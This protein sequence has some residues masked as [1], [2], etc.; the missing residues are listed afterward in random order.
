MVPDIFAIGFV[1]ATMYSSAFHTDTDT[2]VGN[3]VAWISKERALSSNLVTS[4]AS[5][6]PPGREV[7]PSIE[8]KIDG[9]TLERGLT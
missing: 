5:Y 7:V 2:Q 1:K 4:D 3:P 8:Q 6:Q 9:K